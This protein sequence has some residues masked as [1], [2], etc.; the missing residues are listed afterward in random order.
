M[1]VTPAKIYIQIYLY[2]WSRVQYYKME[3]DM[4]CGNN[5]VLIYDEPR[6][7]L[8]IWGSAMCKFITSFITYVDSEICS[9]I[10]SD[11]E[12]CTSFIRHYIDLKLAPKRLNRRM[13]AATHFVEFLLVGDFM[14]NTGTVSAQYPL[15]AIS[16]LEFTIIT[17]FH[18]TSNKRCRNIIRPKI[19]TPVYSDH[20]QRVHCSNSYPQR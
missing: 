9:E 10:C 18:L 13:T 4:W 2:L 19:L 15:N 11:L 1:S 5:G 16:E 8:V 14:A 7:S 3:C 20:D 6:F 12:C 17:F